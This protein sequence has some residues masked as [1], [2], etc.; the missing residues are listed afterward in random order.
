MEEGEVGQRWRV[1]A[2][3]SEPGDGV[4][5]G[6]KSTNPDWLK[7]DVLKKAGKAGVRRVL[8]KVRAGKKLTPLQ[9]RWWRKI[10]EAAENEWD[11]DPEALAAQTYDKAMAAGILPHEPRKL[12]VGDLQPGDQVLINENGLPDLITHQGF[13]EKGDAILKDGITWHADPFETLTSIG[14]KTAAL[15]DLYQDENENGL[16]SR[17]EESDE[18]SG[19]PSSGAHPGGPL[20]LYQ[21]QTEDAAE[22]QRQFDDTAS[23]YGGQEGY[24]RAKEAGR[25]KLNFRQWVQV[26]TPNFKKWFGDWQGLQAQKKLDAMKPVEIR[27]PE[28]W[29]TLA[30]DELRSEVRQVMME[31]RGEK[32]LRHPEIGAVAVQTGGV[33]KSFSASRDPA[34]LLVMGDLKR[35]F[36]KS[37]FAS[38]ISPKQK[39]AEANVNGYEKLLVK[40]NVGGHEMVAAFTVK[41]QTDGGHYYNTVTLNDGHEKTSSAYPAVPDNSRRSTPA[42]DEVGSFIRQ[43]LARVNPNTVSKVIDQDTGEPLVVYHGTNSFNGG[44]GFDT[45]QL[46]E[47]GVE[48][49][50]PGF[51]F[52]EAPEKAALFGDAVMPVFLNARVD[53]KTAKR[54]GQTKDHIRTA[55]GTNYWIVQSPNQIK[56]ATGN[57]GAFSRDNDSILYQRDRSQEIPEAAF[58]SAEDIEY[59]DGSRAWK[60]EKSFRKWFSGLVGDG[61]TTDDKGLAALHRRTGWDIDDEQQD[62][63]IRARAKSGAEVVVG[64]KFSDGGILLALDAPMRAEIIDESGNHLEVDTVDDIRRHVQQYWDEMPTAIVTGQEIGYLNFTATAREIKAQII[65]WAEA[66]GGFFK[67]YTNQE[68]GWRI[69]LTRKGI[70]DTLA[71]GAQNEKTKAIPAL[72]E[73]LENGVYL[74][75]GSRNADGLISHVFAAKASINDKPMVVGFVIR[76]DANGRRFYD[77]ELTETESLG[78]LQPGVTSKTQTPHIRGQVNQGS[79]LN[80]VRKYL[81]V[82][83]DNADDVLYQQ[84]R[85]ADGRLVDTETG[86]ILDDADAANS[87]QKIESTSPSGNKLANNR[88]NISSGN[89]PASSLVNPTPG[90]KIASKHYRAEVGQVAEKL[91]EKRDIGGLTRYVASA[92]YTLCKDEAGQRML[93]AA[94]RRMDN[95]FQE[96]NE[97]IDGL[98]PGA[99]A[100]DYQA[101]HNSF[102]NTFKKLKQTSVTSYDKVKDYLLECDKTGQ[103]FHLGHRPGHAVYDEAG[104]FVGIGR[105]A[106]EANEMVR[107][108]VKERLGVSKKGQKAAERARLTSQ[109]LVKD[110]A[111]LFEVIDPK[112][113]PVGQPLAE[114]EAVAKMMEEEGKTLRRQG[115]SSQ[116]VEAILTFRAMTNRAFDKNIADWRCAEAF[117]YYKQ[118]KIAYRND[119]P[120]FVGGPVD[121][122]VN[123]CQEKRK[124]R[125][126]ISY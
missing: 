119:A 4:W 91:R 124:N 116:E 29:K 61:R 81:G 99:S 7:E 75:S 63:L 86:E 40:V 10:Q 57:T 93:D 41:R 118:A 51:Y 14:E 100:A 109:Y 44:D 123:N 112:G 11:N 39:S 108:H 126:R 121:F 107:D 88:G 64:R 37:I 95:R 111:D 45:F 38:A 105:T 68:T 82:N 84:I 69:S 20:H 2:A 46:K 73:M 15:V 3:W 62:A 30:L 12:A 36:E 97:I 90:Q 113:K 49:Y 9:E 27:V 79:V 33:K 102:I 13:D 6:M 74:E 34:K 17:T 80:V 87:A 92:E 120:G 22:L 18:T 114:T 106:E 78:S 19:T 67:S 42:Y 101:K 43:T 54:I 117:W 70:K 35:A 5:D 72:P 23:A 98:T 122:A 32:P 26:R 31:L 83:A 1:E 16:P 60:N 52:T 56:S 55:D 59:S 110:S 66:R 8:K 76:E 104:T 24:E 25:T 71:H 103:G 21:D 58:L 94:A 115:Y 28:A 89:P 50:G 96:E 48:Q 53:R 65:A 85:L 77:H 125:N 47:G